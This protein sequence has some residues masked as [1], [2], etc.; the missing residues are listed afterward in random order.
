MES[1]KVFSSLLATFP[2]LAFLLRP[3][4]LDTSPTLT[5]VSVN[6]TQWYIDTYLK[7][8]KGGMKTTAIAE[9]VFNV[10]LPLLHRRNP[11]HS[12][13][14]LTGST[15]E[16]FAD[17][18]FFGRRLRVRGP[19]GQPRRALRNGDVLFVNGIHADAFAR[20]VLP[21]LNASF[22]LVTH[23]SDASVPKGPSA[24][25]MLDDPR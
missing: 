11:R 18:S 9:N 8:R 15:L 14:L 20:K 13:P 19:R 4:A 21:K 10:S 2:I 22:I 23:A 7:A 16:A 6:S 12:Y 17:F 5:K 1:W 25:A 3:L 24:I